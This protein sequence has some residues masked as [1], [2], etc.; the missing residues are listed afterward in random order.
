MHSDNEELLGKWFR[1]TGK[2]DEIFLA[3][4]FGIKVGADITKSTFDSSPEYCKEA[5]EKSLEKLGIDCVDLCKLISWLIKPSL[6]LR[7]EAT[8]LRP[9]DTAIYR[10]RAHGCSASATD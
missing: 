3:T 6:L 7:L 2:R 8:Q 5:C 4:K 10:S 9:F 1:R